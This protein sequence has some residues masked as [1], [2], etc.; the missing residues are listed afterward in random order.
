MDRQKQTPEAEQEEGTV[1]SAMGVWRLEGNNSICG[2]WSRS[3]FTE[4]MTF[5]LNFDEFVPVGL[6][7]KKGSL[8]PLSS[9][10]PAARR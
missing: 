1:Q 6:K 4:E 10:F 3:A 5:E 7:R 9:V 8:K 2:G